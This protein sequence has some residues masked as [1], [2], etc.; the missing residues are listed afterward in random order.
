MAEIVVVEDAAPIAELVADHL[1]DAGHEVSVVCDGG[2]ALAHLAQRTPALVVLDVM[3]PGRSGIEVCRW[4]RA[5]PGPQPVVLM[6]TARR[7]EQDALA[8]YDVGVDDYVRKPFSVH[9]LVRRVNALL[10]LSAH[11]WPE[12]AVRCGPVLID[13]A[14]RK[15]RVGDCELGLAP[16]EFDLLL[17]LMRSAGEVLARELL[18][19]QVWGYQHTGYA[20]TVDTH[21]TRLRRKLAKVGVRDA[22][23]TVHSVG[24]C[25]DLKPEAP[26]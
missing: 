11:R 2:G 6:L 8:G 3:L 12:Q 9:E 13:G 24:Y 15:A 17:H 4:L 23:R 21:V 5:R 22:I 7:D 14:T 20:R 10:A 16:L 18:L 25:F 19:R 1:R 26:R